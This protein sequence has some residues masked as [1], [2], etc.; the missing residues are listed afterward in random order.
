MIGYVL[1]TFSD[2]RRAGRLGRTTSEEARARLEASLD[3]DYY[4]LAVL[5]I[6]DHV[7]ELADSISRFENSGTSPVQGWEKN[8]A[9]FEALKVAIETWLDLM[10]PPAGEG[11]P[12]DVDPS[13]LGR[14]IALSQHRYLVERLKIDRE[15]HEMQ[16]SL[17]DEPAFHYSGAYGSGTVTIGE[18][19]TMHEGLSDKERLKIREE[20]E[21]ELAADLRKRTPRRK[22]SKGEQEP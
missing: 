19:A 13:T 5:K 4:D 18:L 3:L 20:A 21:K 7:R 9:L 15:M 22:P 11:S 14:S 12:S 6:S 1:L 8:P 2:E 16:N 10:A 17:K